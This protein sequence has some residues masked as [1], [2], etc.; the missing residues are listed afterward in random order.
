MNIWYKEPAKNWNSALPLGNGRIGAMVFSNPANEKICLN[1]DT[2]WSGYPKK[3]PNENAYESLTKVRELLLLDKLKDAQDLYQDNLVG[4][5]P[6]SY[7]PLGDIL[8][9]FEGH[10]GFCDYKRSLSLETAVL[11]TEYKVNDTKFLRESFISNAD[12]VFVN[13]FMSDKEG[14][15]SFKLC[16]TSQLRN[17]ITYSDDEI[18]V[19][20]ECPDYPLKK[21][22]SRTQAV[23]HTEPSMRGVQFMCMF[24]VISDGHIFCDVDGV[25]VKDATFATIYMAVNTSYNGYDKLPFLEAKEYVDITKN[26]IYAAI[27]KGYEKVKEDHIADYSELFSRLSFTLGGNEKDYLPTDERLIEFYK[28]KEDTNFYA[29]FFQFGRYLTIAASRNG[30]QATNLQ[31]IWNDDMQPP[32]KCDYHLNINTEMNYWPTLSCN[33]KECYG[34]LLD[35]ISDI[36]KAG[37]ITAKEVYGARGFVCHSNSDLWKMTHSAGNPNKYCMDYAGWQ[38]GGAWLSCALYEYYEYTEDEAFLKDIALPIL[39]DCAAFLLD[40]LVEYEG[41]LILCPSNSPENAFVWTDVERQSLARTAVMSTD[42]A[43]E[44]FNACIKAG[45][46]LGI[47]SDIYYEI[48]EKAPKL[49]EYKLGSEGQILEFYEDYEE[50]DVHHRHLSHLLGLYP[51]NTIDVM[52]MPDLAET[53]RKTL[54]R[55]GDGGTGWSS[56]WKINLW[57]RLCDGDHALKI[58][59][60]QLYPAEG[61]YD[62]LKGYFPPEFEPYKIKEEYSG[63][64]MNLFDSHPPFQIDGNFGATSGMCEMLLQSRDGVI[65]ILPAL[66][67][68]WHSGKISGIVAKGNI[69]LSIEWK[70]NRLASLTAVS[71]KN[72]NVKF[73][74]KDKTTLVRLAAGETTEIAI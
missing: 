14:A 71:Q 13:H 47:K 5:Y 73:V 64:Y 25:C 59:D 62:V 2:I 58:L 29:L 41:K 46:I 51:G 69:T 50:I 33:L 12:N 74:Y 22:E 20:G 60:I 8:L 67:E 61:E 37:Q 24:K 44:I 40:N 23:Y 54:L 18:I 53:A 11:T 21:G 66:P 4:V 31:G 17:N 6:Q 38:F 68:I 70:D 1:E 43:K 39:E 52:A 26:Q 63:T 55:R 34:P 27:G 48:K 45:E 9:T 30:C 42:I 65:Y 19:T 56:A 36:H 10:E 57:A 49:P 72:K 32:W 28:N 16:F 3:N 15:I 7:L 35:L